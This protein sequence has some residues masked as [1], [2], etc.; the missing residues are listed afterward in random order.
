MEKQNSLS[1]EQE[2]AGVAETD[3]KEILQRDY[4]RMAY[5]LTQKKI[6]RYNDFCKQ[7]D[8]QPQHDRIKVADFGRSRQKQANKSKEIYKSDG[9]LKL[10][11]E[12]EK[13]ILAAPPQVTE[14][15]KTV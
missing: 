7:N 2:I 10:K 11:R 5:Q 8:L 13:V 6:R 14:L 15:L 1:Q 4:D 3:V 12:P 9:K